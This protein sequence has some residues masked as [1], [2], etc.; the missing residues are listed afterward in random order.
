MRVGVGPYLAPT[1]DGTIMHVDQRLSREQAD[2]LLALIRRN[3]YCPKC[4]SVVDLDEGGCRITNPFAKYPWA[5]RK[6][7]DH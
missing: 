2:F 7:C 5:K 4:V 1:S 6:H 3:G